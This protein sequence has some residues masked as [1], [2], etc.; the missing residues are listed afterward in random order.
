MLVLFIEQQKTCAQNLLVLGPGKNPSVID[1]YTICIYLSLTS[2][3]GQTWIN[4]SLKSYSKQH[5]SFLVIV[6]KKI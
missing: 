4:I 1:L 2:C 5:F 3:P 6:I